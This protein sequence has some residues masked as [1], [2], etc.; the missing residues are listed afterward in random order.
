VGVLVA[1][2]LPAVQ[3]ARESARRAQ[4]ANHLRQIGLAC[5]D[6][7]SAQKFLPSSGWGFKWTGDP[8]RGYGKRQPGGWIFNILD[9]LEESVVRNI[10]RGLSGPGPGGEKYQRLKDQ[11][12]AAIA[13][14]N[15]PTRRR[16]QPYQGTDN[17]LNAAPSGA[18][19]KSDYAANGG[20]NWMLGPGGA[21][22]ECL[23]TFPNCTWMRSEEEIAKTFNGIT[24]ERSEVKLK[25]V[26]DGTSKTLLVSEKY[27]NPWNYDEHDDADDCSM[28]QGNDFD[29]VRWTNRDIAFLPSQDTPGVDSNSFRFGSAH[30][31]AMNAVF[32]DGSSRQISY[33]VDPLVYES[34]GSRNGQEAVN[35]AE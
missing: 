17:C 5:L 33:D 22:I 12:M 20:T 23:T 32:C 24:T 28:Y 29:T 26:I 27:L 34:F 19:A 3:S 1:L 16:A 30:P 9:Y 14:M 31:T 11:K 2:M 15:C 7:E 10:G 13:V 25:Q 6:H 18:Q 4:C 35:A 21:T 8:D